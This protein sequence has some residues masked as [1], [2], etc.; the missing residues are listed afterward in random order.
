MRSFQEAFPDLNLP[1][2]SWF[3]QGGEPLS[4]WIHGL[5]TLKKHCF[6]GVL[7]TALS[8]ARAS[9]HSQ[10][11]TRS[12]AYF[13]APGLIFGF[14]LAILTDTRGASRFRELEQLHFFP[15]G[16]MSLLLQGPEVPE[17][18]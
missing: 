2:E 4:H 15:R 10:H 6:F 8:S 7:K 13:E 12:F 11:F 18:N 16:Q 5:E 3:R 9:Q 17:A 14:L 1:D